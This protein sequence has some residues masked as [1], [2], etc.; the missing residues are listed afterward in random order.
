MGINLKTKT[1]LFEIEKFTK[2]FSNSNTMKKIHENKIEYLGYSTLDPVGRVFNY[3][4][5]IYRGIYSESVEFVREIFKCGLYNELFNND[6][7]IETKISKFYT[8]NF[9]LIL[10]HK[11]ITRSLPTEWTGEMLKEA[12]LLILKINKICEKY[13]YELRDAHPYNIMFNGIKPVWIDFG[14]ISLKTNKLWSALPEFINFSVVPLIYLLSNNLLEGYM[15]LQSETNFK[16]ASNNFRSSLTFKN[17]LELIDKGEKSF[18]DDLIDSAWIN[19]INKKFSKNMFFWSN[20]Q[21]DSDEFK[22][23]TKEHKNNKFNRFFKLPKLIKKYSPDAT[24]LLDLAG[25]NGLAS[26]ICAKKIKFLNKIINTDYDYYSIEKSF[27]I[28]RE[29]KVSKIQTYIM[30]FMLPMHQAVYDNFKSD[31]VI[32]MAITHHLLLSQQFKIS[33]I[34]EKIKKFSKKYVYIEFMPLG[35][36]GGDVTTKPEV[37]KWYTQKQFEIEF[38]KYFELMHI[39]V[40]ESHNIARKNEAHRV[41]FIGKIK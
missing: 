17:F 16:I 15:V 25:N 3:N 19:N 14:S 41:L 37:P 9:P 23:N 24:S 26:I 27:Q 35:M 22:N 38:C 8:D 34:F 13:G 21:S 18:N 7:L 36:W 20:Y 11:K 40:L 12:S 4:N 30:N 6:L 28:I 31:I 29:L 1:V 32:A 39:E 10:S 33:E 2:I 5:E